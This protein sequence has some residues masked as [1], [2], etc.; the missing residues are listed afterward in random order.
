MEHESFEN[1]EIATIMNKN[2]IS[3]KVDR[4][5][6]PDIDAVYM[7]AVQMMSGHGGWPLNVWLTPDLIPIYGGTYFPPETTHNR[8]GFADVLVRMA[9]IFKNDPDKINQRALEMHEALKKD[10]LQHIDRSEV[11][12]TTLRDAIKTTKKH[13]DEINGGFSPAP[14]FPASMHIEFLLRYDKLIGEPA[15]RDMAI[16]T[17]R[18]MCLGGIYDQLG[19][20]FH[21]YCTDSRWLVPHFE[22]MLYDNALLISALCDA[23]QVSGDILFEQTLD[24]TVKFIQNEM[25][26]PNGE[27][28]AS[29]DAD[30]DGI[31]GAF[32]VWSFEELRQL[33]P[34]TDFPEFSA[35]YDVYKGGNWEDRVI[36]NRMHSS[37]DFSILTQANHVDLLLRISSWKKILI[38]E[39]VKR[40]PPV[41]D[42]KVITSWNALMLRSLCKY[43]FITLDKEV[44][45]LILENAN[46]LKK[47]A[48]NASDVYRITSIEGESTPGFCDDYA[49]LIEAFCMVFKVTGDEAWLKLSKSMTENMIQIFYDSQTHSFSYTRTGQED[50]IVRKND[51]FDNVTPS[52]NSSAIGACL[53]VGKLTGD[54]ELI[55][56][57]SRSI[58]SLGS[59]LSDHALSFGYLLQIISD[60][61][62]HNGSEIVIL[63]SENEKFL[64]VLSGR[65]L[66]FATVVNGNTFEK[67]E[68]ETFSGKISP[69]HGTKVYLCKD[70]TCLKPIQDLESF[71]SQI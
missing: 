20:G 62:S 5:E 33:L 37:L 66:P 38:N 28:Y 2:Y 58:E 52:A 61:L 6:R 40:N 11:S 69:P 21:R 65:Y 1:E 3:I 64:E 45:N 12:M 32:Y 44:L 68:F 51:L 27:F 34:E 42:K 39:R 30:S 47:N 4:E 14:K 17:M 25:T 10:V 36:L 43:W 29:I 63:G 54:T 9:N 56:I 26:G 19:G 24:E 48:T 53:Q 16:F 71:R 41:T 7:E 13:Y 57:V 49:Q 50:L 23:F 60:K 55:H 46:Y 59:I 8:L 15:S 67:S 70:F 22:K 18:K 31:E 35:Y